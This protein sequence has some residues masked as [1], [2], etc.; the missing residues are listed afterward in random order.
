M[1]T[2]DTI[3]TLI[4]TYLTTYAP[5]GANGEAIRAFVGIPGDLRTPE[6]GAYLS[7]MSELEK[8]G[9]LDPDPVYLGEESWGRWGRKLAS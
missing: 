8:E 4:I 3:K 7:A 1:L 2:T 5:Q 9:V 6:G